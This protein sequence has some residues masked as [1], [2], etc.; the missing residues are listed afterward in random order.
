MFLVVTVKGSRDQGEGST[1][2]SDVPLV[3]ATWPCLQNQSDYDG[4][5]TK[6]PYIYLKQTFRWNVCMIVLQFPM[7]NKPRVNILYHRNVTPTRT[8]TQYKRLVLPSRHF[9]VMFVK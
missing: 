3:H 6:D 4:W 1:L 9:S 2:A 8:A 5:H 7:Y